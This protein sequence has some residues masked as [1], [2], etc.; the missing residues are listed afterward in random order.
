[1]S[2]WVATRSHRGA[3]SG[4]I[5]FVQP[6]QNQIQPYE[7]LSTQPQHDRL[8]RSHRSRAAQAASQL[9]RRPRRRNAAGAGWWRSYVTS[10]L[11]LRA[12]RGKP[13][14]P[15][16]KGAGGACLGGHREALRDRS[17]RLRVSRRSD[18]SGVR[19]AN[20]LADR[21]SSRK[22]FPYPPISACPPRLSGPGSSPRIVQPQLA[23]GLRP[24]LTFVVRPRCHV[25]H[26]NLGAQTLS[27]MLG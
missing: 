26:W 24:M 22:L 18:R 19:V 16:S 11:Q 20:S 1:M 12:Q 5:Q 10:G 4:R 9:A 8:H 6:N 25:F 7:N 15:D 23:S 14:R 27:K 3:R 13:G 2:C 17:C 21:Q